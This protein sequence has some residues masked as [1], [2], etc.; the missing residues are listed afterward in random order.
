M[1]KKPAVNAG[2]EGV[3]DSRPISARGR[4]GASA[5]VHCGV[6]ATTA[7]RRPRQER[8]RF[9]VAAI[10]QAA[11]SVIDD[12]GWARASTNRIAEKAG[13]SIGSLY[14]YFP[15]KEAILESLLDE[16]QRVV[17]EVVA[18]AMTR[19]EDPEISLETA[20]TQL[21][22]ELLE[23]HREDPVVARVLS[24]EV[25]PH[26]SGKDHEAESDHFVGWLRAILERR[27][28]IGVADPAVAAHV[29]ATTTEALTRWIAHE[30]PKSVDAD[31]F[32]EEAVRMLAG[33]LAGT[34]NR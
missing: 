34:P 8:A 7:R 29:V 24:T 3:R 9:T 25:P 15:N 17:H 2:K 19:L 13:V 28:D 6:S 23:V 10:L 32:V 11:A 14:Q 5:H 31:V 18:R 26:P 16:H 30:S 22:R 33:Y 21:F 20:L 4:N 27:R 1:T 12:V